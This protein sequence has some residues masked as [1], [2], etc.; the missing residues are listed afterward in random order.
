MRTERFEMRLTPD[1]IRRVDEWRSEQAG[2]PSRAEAVRRLIDVGLI[3]SLGRQE[4]TV[5]DGEKLLLTILGD[6]CRHLQIDNN[7][8][9]E[10]VVNA[11]SEGRYWA[12]QQQYD[13]LLHS[14]V[15]D[16][17]VVDEVRDV[18]DMWRFI[19]EDYARLSKQDQE[20]VAS[21]G[22][23]FGEHVAFRGFD[24]KYEG[25][26]CATTRFLIDEMG[27]FS[28][29][30]GRDFYTVGFRMEGYRRMLEIF[31][32]I[33]RTLDGPNKRLSAAQII[34]L[35]KTETP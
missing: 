10:F 26:Y 34:K 18:L 15:Q 13:Y 17:R 23:P 1:T 35:L 4:I 33:R 27:W 12:L 9:P 31:E 30:K 5:S 32:P 11:I 22:G 16:K 6:I 7:V 28:G 2:L 24:H 19:E 3:M 20:L 8:D 14:R 29:F 25:E 21:E